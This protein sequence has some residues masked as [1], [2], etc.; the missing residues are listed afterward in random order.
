MKYKKQYSSIITII[1]SISLLLFIY[2]TA[3]IIVKKLDY[4]LIPSHF[5]MYTI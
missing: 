2:Y 3:S 5:N 4:Y 1:V